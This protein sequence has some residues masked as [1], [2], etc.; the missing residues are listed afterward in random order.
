MVQ[1][2]A[3]LSGRYPKSFLVHGGQK[4]EEHGIVHNV[5]VVEQVVL[6][7]SQALKT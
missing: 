2:P 7:K 5:Q 4:E 6:L 1:I 3:L